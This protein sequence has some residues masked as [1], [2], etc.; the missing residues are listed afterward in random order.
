MLAKY[1]LCTTH[2]ITS[3]VW[4]VPHLK[5][6]FWTLSGVQNVLGKSCYFHLNHS[7]D[8]NRHYNLATTSPSCPW[9]SL[10]QHP[11]SLRFP[12]THFDDHCPPENPEGSH[13][14]QLLNVEHALQ[15]KCITFHA[16]IVTVYEIGMWL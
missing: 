3:L 15:D 5:K 10:G 4:I 13:I 16:V 11:G 2:Q 9:K 8:R 1:F 14:L 7:K 12:G 6:S